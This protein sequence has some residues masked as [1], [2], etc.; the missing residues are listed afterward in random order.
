[1]PRGPGTYGKKRGRPK[2][3]KWL[4]KA[5]AS[6]KRRGTV[7]AFTRQAKAKGMGVQAYASYVIRRFKG[8]PNLTASQKTLF[9]RAVFAR[10]MRRK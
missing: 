7:G 2:K 9:R 6:M 10:N 5:V 4:Q 1:M 8:K 3:K